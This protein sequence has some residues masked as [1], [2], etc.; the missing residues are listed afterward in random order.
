MRSP[1]SASS[2]NR[3]TQG[4]IEKG[5]VERCISPRTH[6]KTQD[7]VRGLR[8]DEARTAVGQQVLGMPTQAEEAVAVAPRRSKRSTRP[9]VINSYP[10]FI[11]HC[12]FE[13]LG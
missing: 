9:S 3:T 4:R 2:I 12:A 5:D 11:L 13:N 6:S 7:G 10:C 8:F 1:Y